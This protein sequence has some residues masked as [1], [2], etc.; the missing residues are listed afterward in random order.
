MKN[1]IAKTASAVTALLTAV[2]MMF[3]LVACQK[4]TDKM[5][6][7]VN[8]GLSKV[9]EASKSEYGSAQ[10]IV[11]LYS[12][13][14][15][16]QAKVLG[17]ELKKEAPARYQ[18]DGT[19]AKLLKEKTTVLADLYGKGSAEVSNYI[20]Y[21]SGNSSQSPTPFADDLYDAYTDA[22]N[23]LMDDYQDALSEVM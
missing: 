14:M 9:E 19:L 16:K 7:V 21:S 6:E 17:K 11:D 4:A 8:S 15:E 23:I 13:K 12:A 2:V 20:L 22:T 3:S 18:Q 5:D 10:E 1:Y